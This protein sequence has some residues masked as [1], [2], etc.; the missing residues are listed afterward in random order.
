MAEN[1]NPEARLALLCRRLGNLRTEIEAP[2]KD[3]MVSKEKLTEC[4]LSVFGKL[5]T[6]SNINYQAFLTTMKK[7]WKVDS[8]SLTQY[9]SGILSFTFSNDLDKNRVLENSPWSFAS[10]LLILTPWVPNKPPHCYK[11]TSCAFWVQVHGLPMEW[12]SMEM[13]SYVTQILGVVQEVK[14]EKKGAA[15]HRVGR[16]KVVLNLDSPLSPGIFITLEEEK[17]WLDFKYER[18]PRFCYSCGKI[19]HYTT[20]CPVIPYDEAKNGDH[21]SSKF[22]LWLKAEARESSPFWN[23]FYDEAGDVFEGMEEDE[24][25]PET[26]LQST[27]NVC[28]EK[29]KNVEI[30]KGARSGQEPPFAVATASARGKQLALRSKEV[31]TDE[32]DCFG[33][34]TDWSKLNNPSNLNKTLKGP[35]TKKLK[36]N[37]PYSSLPQE[38]NLLEETQLQDTPIRISDESAEW[39]LVASPNKPPGYK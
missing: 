16:A 29:E 36:R 21:C 28:P 38:L 2:Q 8:V 11:F 17:I 9:E 30:E 20:N 23:I 25:L 5:Y 14:I 27:Q 39:A 19:G 31:R 6:S 13:V 35:L 15:F 22:G 37:N 10:N 32:C 24:I 4:S 18:L 12:C 33:Q 3:L 7:A 34:A 1:V 26:P